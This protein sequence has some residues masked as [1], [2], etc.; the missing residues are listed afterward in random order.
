VRVANPSPGEL[1]ELMNGRVSL[2]S[3]ELNGWLTAVSA[4]LLAVV[5]GEQEEENPDRLR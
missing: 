2:V 1:E 4:A 5:L 3:S